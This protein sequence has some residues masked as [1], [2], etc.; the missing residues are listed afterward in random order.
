[1]HQSPVIARRVVW[2]VKLRRREFHSLIQRCVVW[3][4]D[5]VRRTFISLMTARPNHS[6]KQVS[7]VVRM[8]GRFETLHF[9]MFRNKTEISQVIDE[10]NLIPLE[11][12][13]VSRSLFA[14]AMS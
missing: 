12:I 10:R 13:A 7:L 6:L 4:A 3:H 9:S 5:Y 14:V 2:F 8:K 1:M 11:S